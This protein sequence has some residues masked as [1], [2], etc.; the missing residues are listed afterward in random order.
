MF[1]ASK[2]GPMLVLKR[3]AG[4]V[5]FL[6]LS[7][8]CAQA[9]DLSGYAAPSYKD[10]GNYW[11]ITIGGYG[12]AEP[13]FPGAKDY[14]FTGRPIIDIH[15]AGA[16]EWLALP[17]D[18]FSLSLYQTD[19]FR[20]G[21]AGDYLNHRQQSDAP[22]ELKGM[23]NIDYTLEAGAFAEYYPVPFLRT[24]VEVLQGLTGAEGLEANFMADFIYRP[25][26]QWL[27]TAGPRMQVVNDKFASAFY[28]VTSA[29]EIP[30]GLQQFRAAGGIN[31]AGIDATA[32]Y[33]MTENFSLRAFAEWD[34]LLGDA[35]D[36]PLV[37][38][39]GSPDQLQFGLG[40]AYKFN[41]SW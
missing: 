29:E 40:A 9:A 11:V 35:A 38:Q 7:A 1:F 16:K 22:S 34:R 6:G 25:A 39:K 33:D 24:R 13:A 15:Q 32:R 27:F 3:V 5:A 31:Y 4:F 18:A 14:I 26:P 30:S 17:N 12:V 37:K 28:S 21:V 41:Y 36:S 20:V 10:A 8:G 19:N 23:H 2:G